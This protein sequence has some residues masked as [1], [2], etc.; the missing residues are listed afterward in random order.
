MSKFQVPPNTEL[1]VSPNIESQMSPNVEITNA[2]NT[3]FHLS[4]NRKPESTVAKILHYK[5]GHCIDVQGGSNSF[6]KEV[7]YCI[8]LFS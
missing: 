2:D 4:P 5:Y 8:V 1:Q 7:F 6:V 3:K